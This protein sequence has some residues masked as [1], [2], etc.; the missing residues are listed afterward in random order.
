M[1]MEVN[2]RQDRGRSLSVKRKREYQSPVID[3]EEGETS[4]FDIEDFK[5]L[6]VQNEELK[7]M[8]IKLQSQ[9]ELLLNKVTDL[10]EEREKPCYKVLDTPTPKT[11]TIPEA[12]APRTKLGSKPNSGP[13]HHADLQNKS[14]EN[15]IAS[16]NLLNDSLLLEKK[17]TKP[18]K[19]TMAEIVKAA[20]KNTQDGVKNFLNAQKKTNAPR[21]IHAAVA[22]QKNGFR[23]MFVKNLPWVPIK[24]LKKL[25]RD[26]H[27]RTKKIVHIKAIGRTIT[28]LIVESDYVTTLM[29][30]LR[31]LNCTILRDFNPLVG[32][33]RIT[34]ESENTA[35]DHFL[36]GCIKIV[37]TDQ[38]E[39]LKTFIRE[40]VLTNT[41]LSAALAEAN[42]EI[43]TAFKPPSNTIVDLVMSPSI[44]E[45]QIE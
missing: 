27:I 10:E 36:S 9:V 29:F 23:Y 13:A 3:K 44:G 2:E 32:P 37:T 20:P 14:N 1:M 43:Q 6:R 18:R 22:E 17:Q 8:I 34:E 30:R 38:N 40:V 28:Q 24:Q 5:S 4:D 41:K 39:E 21:S 26:M 35:I 7:R 12:R 15:G 42:D 31:N 25:F 11:K 19:P 16:G 45:E 33:N